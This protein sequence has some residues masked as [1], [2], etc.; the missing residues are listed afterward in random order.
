VEDYNWRDDGSVPSLDELA[1]FLN[2]RSYTWMAGIVQDRLATILQALRQ[3]MERLDDLARVQATADTLEWLLGL[4]P[5]T[6][7]STT[8]WR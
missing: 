4:I 7:E 1:D 8:A 3:P 2:T 6:I 5:N